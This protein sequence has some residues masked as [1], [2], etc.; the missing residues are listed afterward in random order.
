MQTL[1]LI[2]GAAKSLRSKQGGWTPPHR[3]VVK[4]GSSQAVTAPGASASKTKGVKTNH[5]SLVNTGE[6]HMPEVKCAYD[7]MAPLKDLKMNPRNPKS[8]AKQQVKALARII[9][10]QGRLVPITVSTRSGFVV[11][12]HARLISAKLLQCHEALVDYQDYSNE[13]EEWADLVA[14]NHIA[15][16]AEMNEDLLRML[17]HDINTVGYDLELTVLTV[18]R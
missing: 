7:E 14:D 9:T 5:G 10:A 18:A 11:R 1:I 13:A 15:E 4:Y 6:V 17:M 12:G 2:F 16:L 3:P 8:H